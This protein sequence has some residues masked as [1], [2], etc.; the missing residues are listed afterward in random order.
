MQADPRISSNA[1]LFGS[2]GEPGHR[3]ASVRG[4]QTLM[5]GSR[6][7]LTECGNTPTDTFSWPCVVGSVG[8]EAGALDSNFKSLTAVLTI[9]F[10]S[11]GLALDSVGCLRSCDF[12]ATMIHSF[13]SW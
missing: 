6:L 7:V 4:A 12:F 5:H 13:R 2:S 3:Q 10:K 8:L 11:P 1:P 9:K